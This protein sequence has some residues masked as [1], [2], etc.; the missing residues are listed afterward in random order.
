MGPYGGYQSMFLK[1]GEFRARYGHL[2]DGESDVPFFTASQERI[3]VTAVNVARGFFGSRWKRHARFVVLNET[4]ASGLNTLT[5]ELGCPGFDGRF[6]KEYTNNYAEIGLKSALE[7]FRGDLPGIGGNVSVGDVANLMALCMYDL[8]VVG[9]SPLCGYFTP[10]DWKAFEYF[11]DLDY[12]YYSGN[13]NPVVPA[14]GSVVI[15]A[16]TS[17]LQDEANKQGGL[18][19]NFAHETN[20]LMYLTA[21]GLVNPAYDLDWRAADF[22]H[23]WTTSQIVPMGT[24]LEVQRL[25]CSSG[26]GGEVSRHVRFVLNDA[27]I[28]HD[29]CTSG[30]GFSC[31]LDEF[32]EIQANRLQD[33]IDKCKLG[34]DDSRHDPRHLTFYWDWQEQPDKYP[35]WVVDLDDF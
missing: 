15:N 17:L 25:K 12:Y 29:T 27:V 8:N 19:F 13:G 5:P 9:K 20:V 7:R 32:V 3:V 22:K 35:N 11:R 31:P 28:P 6:R 33:P 4:A 30:P 26:K 14:L 23:R 1:G 18:F 2:W 10:D 24:R 21:L 16:T 34:K